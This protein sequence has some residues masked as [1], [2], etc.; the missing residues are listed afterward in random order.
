M[1]ARFDEHKNEKDLRKAKLLLEEGE[2]ELKRT[3][4]YQPLK[5]EFFLLNLLLKIW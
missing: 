3:M 4:H 2:K 1:R 5:C